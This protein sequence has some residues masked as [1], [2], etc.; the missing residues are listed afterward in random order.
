MKLLNLGCGE[1]Q[2]TKPWVNVDRFS[3]LFPPDAPE[4]RDI[5]AKDNYI[6][7]DLLQPLP[8]GDNTFLGVLCSHILEHFPAQEGVRML[9]EARRVLVPGAPL[10][11]SV[12]DCS[13]FRRVHGEDRNENWPRLFDTTD[14]NNPIPTFFD[15]ALW[16]NEHAAILTEDALWCYLVR[17]GFCPAKCTLIPPDAELDSNDPI[18]AQLNR[19]KFSVIMQAIK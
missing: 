1:C 15:A 2:L 17:A 12:P 10:I 19:R 3:S 13:Y 14:P 18:H 7:A 9:A 6:D 16:F 4:L 11:V 5:L 8:F